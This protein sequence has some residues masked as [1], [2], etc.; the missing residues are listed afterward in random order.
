MAGHSLVEAY[1]VMTR[2]PQPNRIPASAALNMIATSFVDGV[3][4]IS[5][6]A[7]AYVA[8]LE[9]LAAQGIAGGAVYDAVIAACA[10]LG[11]ADTILTFND[12]HFARFAGAGLEVVVPTIR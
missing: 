11:G 1:S 2:V 5:L 8:L 7:L 6:D 3:R 9:D 10:R 4:V 12:R